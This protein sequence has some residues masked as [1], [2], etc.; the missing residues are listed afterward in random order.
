MRRKPKTVLVTTPATAAD[1]L[2]SEL[3]QPVATDLRM[4]VGGYAQRSVWG[5]GYPAT[6]PKPRPPKLFSR[7]DSQPPG[8]TGS[9]R[10][11]FASPRR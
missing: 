3:W 6:A 9:G 7:S 5:A 10:R 2:L 11:V 4:L 1:E 8:R